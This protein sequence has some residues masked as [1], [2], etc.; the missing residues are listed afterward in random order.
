MDF[1]NTWW[2]DEKIRQLNFSEN[3]KKGEIQGL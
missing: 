3:Q 1:N 2:E